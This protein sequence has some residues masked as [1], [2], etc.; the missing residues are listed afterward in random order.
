MRAKLLSRR[1]HKWLAI[2]VGAQLLVWALSGFYMVAVHIDIIHGD[3][4]VRP[5]DAD[6]G[7][8][9]DRL[10]PIPTLLERYPDTRAV[11]LARR[12]ELPIYRLDRETGREVVDARSGEP[13]DPLTAEQAAA[14][15]T[16]HFS[17]A[18]LVS[19]TTLVERDPPSEIQF[20]PLPVWRVDFDDAWGTSFYVH[21]DTGQFMTRRHTLWRVFDFLWMLHIMDYDTRENI[22]NTLLRIFAAMALLL[23]ITGTW[24]VWLRFA[25]ARAR[26]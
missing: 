17:G 11:T 3:M 9:L 22:N 1:L 5:V 15:A 2:L 10:L 21:P 20:L 26:T 4:L 8:S 23:G 25:P 6:L 12:G 14:I 13:L 24:L 19:A 7:R 16:H 18:A